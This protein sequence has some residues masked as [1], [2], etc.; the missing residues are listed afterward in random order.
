MRYSFAILALLTVS[1]VPLAAHAD[2]VSFSFTT[3]AGGS[4]GGSVFNEPVTITGSFDSTAVTSNTGS[5]S[6]PT[7]F[8]FSFD[9]APAV[10]SAPGS[11]SLIITPGSDEAQLVGISGVLFTLDSSDLAGLTA[12]TSFTASGTATAAGTTEN[13][14]AFNSTFPVTFSSSSGDTELSLVAPVTIPSGPSP[15]PEPSSLLFLST[16]LMGL[17][18]SAR[19]RFARR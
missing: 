16:G 8:S 17:A 9:G 1:A 3:T 19:R 6:A 4:F 18:G 10:D 13:F 15:V 11:E 2:T 7:T 5:F 14:D 12:L